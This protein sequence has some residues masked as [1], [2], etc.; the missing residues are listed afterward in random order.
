MFQGFAPFSPLELAAADKWSEAWD[1][2]YAAADRAGMQY[3][4]ATVCPGYDDHALDDPRRFGNRFRRV[5]RLNGETYAK[6]IAW[7][8]GLAVPPHLAIVSTFNEMHENTHIEPSI[9]N[10][11]RYVDMT[12]DFVARIKQ[13]QRRADAD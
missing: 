1:A 6:S 9:R 13:S 3:R 12:K 11:M 7:L 2:A 5:P 4:I 10:G 8:E